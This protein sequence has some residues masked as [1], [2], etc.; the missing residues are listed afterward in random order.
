MQTPC[1]KLRAMLYL[2]SCSIE[3]WTLFLCTVKLLSVTTNINNH[4]S[5]TIVTLRMTYH[6]AG[7]MT[8]ILGCGHTVHMPWNWPAARG[9]QA[10]SQVPPQTLVGSLCPH[11]A[12]TGHA[13]SVPSGWVST[14][15]WQADASCYPQ[16]GN[17]AL[18][19][20]NEQVWSVHACLRQRQ[21]E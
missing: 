17:S 3:I 13:S 11:G 19:R 2:C 4:N 12:H 14:A 16:S 20:W 1:L 8:V 6:A 7:E 21:R 9:N 5:D 18:S 10:V 15:D